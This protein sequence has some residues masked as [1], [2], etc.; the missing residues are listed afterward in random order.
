MF[1]EFSIIGLSLYDIFFMLGIVAALLILRL[2]S[3]KSGFSAKLFNFCL[4]DGV[5]SITCGYG[6]AVLF[7]A[8]YN[9]LDNGKFELSATTGATFYGGLIGGVALFL[10][11]YFAVG[12]FRFPDGEHR[13]TVFKLIGIAAC[14]ITAAHAL[15]RVGCFTVGCC[16]GHATE[17]ALGI[18]M[19]YPG[20]KVLPTQLWE[21]VFLGL[22]CAWLIVRFLKNKSYNMPIYMASYGIWRFFIEYFRGDH[23]G[24]TVVSFLTPSQLVAVILVLGAGVVWYLEKQG[25][26]NGV[27]EVKSHE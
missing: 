20:Y 27:K 14:S 26:D 3:D 4:L 18:F 16:H 13:A 9:F 19:K 15:G 12:H 17:S 2:L 11:I 24:E 7:Q 22:L 23:R 1:P 5:L 8:F 10:I 6:S 21:A 25:T